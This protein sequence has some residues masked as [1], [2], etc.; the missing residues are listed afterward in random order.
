MVEALKK[1]DKKILII[2]GILLFVP[3]AIIIFL[4]IVQGCS[5]SKITPE[6]YEE[7]MIEA[8]KK[9][10]EDSNEKYDKKIVKLNTLIKK[11][12]IKAPE[13]LLG[14]SSCEGSVIASKNVITEGSE[15]VVN[16]IVNLECDNYSTNTLIKSMMKDLVE[17]GSGLYKENDYYLYRG[18]EVNN[19]VK[20]FNNLY[21]IININPDGIVKMIKVESESL[22]RYW[23]NKYNVEINDIYGIN[24]YKDSEI[25]KS[26]LEDY[27]NPKVISSSAKKHIVPTDV[28]VDSKSIQDS[29]IKN[30]ECVNKLENQ[31]VT[32]IDIY[33]YAKASLD[34]NCTGIYSK[35]CG[36]YNYMKDLNLKTWT[37]IAVSENS[38]QV[39]YLTGSI[40]KFQEASKYQNYNLVIHIDGNEK[41]ASGKGT[42]SVPYVIE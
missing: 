40:I 18:D 20:F 38:Y 11:E 33:D 4:A 6:K 37:P 17:E 22:D 14:D 9:Y 2:I 5:N 26:L 12:Y 34:V 25:L 35:S 7:K 36:N 39:Y 19:Y 42:L 28:C 13:E 3:I 10:L 30:Y 8:T 31:V 24:L 16:Y 1:I 23:D 21:R 29:T 15:D 27:N 41:I 32:L